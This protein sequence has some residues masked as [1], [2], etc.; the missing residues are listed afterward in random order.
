GQAFRRFGYLHSLSQQMNTQAKKIMATKDELIENKAQLERMRTTA[1]KMRNLRVGELTKLKVEEKES[2]KLVNTLRRSSKKYKADLA[3]KRRQ[4]EALNRE[5][6][7]IIRAAMN[8]GTTQN[9][10][11][12][13]AAPIDYTLAK[14]FAANKGKLP[15]PVSGPVI[16]SYGQ[17]YHPVYKNVKLPF[18]NG[19]TIATNDGEPVKAVFDGVVKQIVVMP[20]YNQCILVQH[21]NYFSFYCKLG[22]VSVKAGDKIKTGQVLGKVGTIGG[23]TQFHLQIWFGRTPQNP[24][25]W[26]RPR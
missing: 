14:E 22:S 21:G 16:D 23:E 9:K 13:A 12:K 18:N 15:W 3:S 8:Q 17:H 11:K 2:N 26:L 25:S 10:N 19:I 1:Q 7:R 20:G 6:E 24:Q 4:V 5:I